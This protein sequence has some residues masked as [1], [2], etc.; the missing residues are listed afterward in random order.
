MGKKEN[1]SKMNRRQFLQTTAKVAG[2]ALFVGLGS[3]ALF[4]SA[5]AARISSPVETVMLNNGAQMPILGFGTLYLTD[6]LGIRCVDDAISLGYR[7]FDT[8][9][10][11]GNEEAVGGG[12][13]RNGID[14]SELFITSK[15]WVEDTGYENTKRAFQTSLDKLQTDYLDLYLIHRPRGDVNGSWKAMEELYN[16]GKIKAIGVSNFT[17]AQINDL[18]E[19]FS[20]KPA[21]NQIETHAFFQQPDEL[22]FL[23]SHNILHEAWSPLAQGRN[24]YFT[25]ETLAAI[26]QKYGKSNAQVALRWHYQRGIVA[27]PRTSKKA[28]MEENLNIFDFNLSESE[29]N[30]IASLDLN[31][32][33]FPEWE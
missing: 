23:N 2:S 20:V 7:L 32:T 21:V 24:G 33:Q 25:N 10:I 1:P 11:Y 3:S 13:K 8:A 27:I 17:A 19:N 29:M 12:I 4:G 9:T 31:K 18:I 6:E 28:H 15:V 5:K 14:R 22:E 30:R 16:E 26:G